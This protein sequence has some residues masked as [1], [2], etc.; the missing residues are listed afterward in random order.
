MKTRPIIPVVLFLSVVSLQAAT[1]YILDFNTQS[2]SPGLT[3][4][5]NYAISPYTGTVNGTTVSL[6]CD[7]FNDNIYYGQQNVT[8][9]STALTANSASIDDDTRYGVNN[10]PNSSY[11]AG[12]QL[13][14]ELAWL[15]TQMRAQSGNNATTNDIAI[16]EAIWTMT[17]DTSGPD[18]AGPHN[19]STELSGSALT[20]ATDTT[21]QGYLN[22]ITDAQNA[23]TNG[24]AAQSGYATLV[25]SDWYIVTAVG[26]A[27]CTIGSNGSNGCTPGTAGTGDVTQ[28]FLA[29][30]S[31]NGGLLTSNVAGSSTPEPASFFL[32]GSGLLAGSIL[33][34]RRSNKTSL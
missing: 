10:A 11:T 30:Y 17:N 31:G 14:N 8:V 27:G 6:Y 21:A 9:Y 32:I 26:S 12:T 5:G 25:S 3:F 24:F 22:W 1:S 33:I 20:N 28:E 13:Y 4:D 34:R 29:Y 19:A 7:D 2:N 15:T 18:G 23:N 16:Q